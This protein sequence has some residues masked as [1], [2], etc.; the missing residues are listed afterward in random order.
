MAKNTDIQKL[1]NSFENFGSTTVTSKTVK[2]TID[3]N[4]NIKGFL[5]KDG[6]LDKKSLSGNLKFTLSNAALINFEPIQKVGKIV[7][8][9]RDFKNVTIDK[10]NCDGAMKNG[11]VT[12]KP[13]EI[14]TSVIQL[15]VAGDYGFAGGTNMQ[16]DVHLRNP[17]KDELA[18]NNG[19]HI[20]KK[21]NGIIIH[22]KAHD[23]KN[24]KTK[25]SLGSEKEKLKE[26][27]IL[28]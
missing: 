19:A 24:G 2:G 15:D 6:G 25:I 5:I 10:M 17:K 27:N 12:I 18:K 14:K 26:T 22:L 9:N 4:T 3:L 11:I 7:F 8:P 1:L 28:K 20:T 16:V 23:D 21:N 13:M